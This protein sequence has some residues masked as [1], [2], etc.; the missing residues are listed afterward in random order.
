MVLGAN[1]WDIEKV[2]VPGHT[3]FVASLFSYSQLWQ[4]SYRDKYKTLNPVKTE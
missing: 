4:I 1:V 3:T 2:V